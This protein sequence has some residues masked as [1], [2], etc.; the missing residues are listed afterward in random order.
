MSSPPELLELARLHG[1]QT[2]YRDAWGHDRVASPEALGG[3]LASLGAPLDRPSD[4]ADALAERRRELDERLAPPVVVVWEGKEVYVPLRLPAGTGT[5][6][7]QLDLESGDR[8][9]TSIDAATLRPGDAPGESLLPVVESVPIGYHHLTVEVAGR[10][11]KVLILAA[12]RRSFELEKRGLWGGF[13]PLY[14]LHT[15]ESWG[16]GDFSDLDRLARWIAGYGGG[17]VATLPLLATFLDREPFEPSPYA[18]ASRL[19]WNEVYVDPRRLPEFSGSPAARALAESAEFRAE[20][21]ALAALPAVD[22]ARTAALKRQVLT[23][24]AQGTLSLSDGR[25][26]EFERFTKSKPYVLEYAR[27][28]AAGEQYGTS[29][30]GWPEAERGGNLAQADVRP[31]AVRYHLYA[32]WAAEQQLGELAAAARSRGPGL[33][34]DLPLGVH[35]SS[36]DVWRFP[37]LFARGGSAGAPPDALFQGGQN[38]GFPPIHPERQRERGYDYLIASLRHHLAHAGLLRID[39]V[40]QLHRLFWVP[41][42]LPATEGVY[43]TYP[44]EELYAVLSIESHRHRAALVG[45]NLG[46]VAAEVY[47]AMDRHAILGLFVAQYEL[48]PDGTDLIRNPPANTAASLNTHDMPPFH[49]YW[50]GSEIEDLQALGAIDDEMAARDRDRRGRLRARLTTAVAVTRG[51][52]LAEDQAF[53]QVS[54]ALHEHLAASPAPIALVNL[55]DLWGETRP[56]NVPGTHVERPNW[57][58]KARY[59]LEEMAEQPEVRTTLAR[60]EA[61]RAEVRKAPDTIER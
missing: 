57:R 39:H 2:A 40:M 56:Q 13:L 49:A 48:D 53:S 38:W 31:E 10:R 22:W 28:R 29:W 25:R 15:K 41:N 18:P 61:L 51:G 6:A 21:A 16:V 1:V 19:F 12:P 43:V 60:M 46:T 44:A 9:L 14:A 26:A 42:G 20:A 47:E 52:G 36:F 55:E 34:L 11:A 59:S 50:Q 30:Q 45:E 58:R 17:L 24:L 8:W 54:L 3:V 35:S 32:Q 33:Y 5:F 37:D 27:F 7:C 23:E 4:A